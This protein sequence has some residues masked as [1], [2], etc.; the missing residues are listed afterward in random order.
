MSL[1]VIDHKKLNLVLDLVY[2]TENN[3]INKA[4][5]KNPALMLHQEAAEKLAKASELANR[6]GFK[7]KVFDGFRPI[8]VQQIFYDAFPGTNYVSNPLTGEA[9]HCRGIAIDLT[10][11]DE[12]GEEL[13][14]GTE[15][16]SFEEHAHHGNKNISK[17]AQKNR[18]I[19][20]GIMTLSGWNYY[21]YEWWHYQLH[22]VQNY[23]KYY[24]KDAPIQMI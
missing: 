1:V 24:D 20:L 5:Y 16:D 19:L 3:F 11:V 2:G 7:I 6:M 23:K 21:Q 4:V 9:T 15:F 8:E 17:L 12:E 14:M 13:D 22:N 18:A 10:L